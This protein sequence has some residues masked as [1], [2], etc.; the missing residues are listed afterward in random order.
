MTGF[1]PA[2]GLRSRKGI[3]PEHKLLVMHETIL[4][5]INQYL[6]RS[7]A[8]DRLYAKILQSV[9]HA[10]DNQPPD[11]WSDRY[12]VLKWIEVFRDYDLP[13][14]ETTS[15]IAASSL[16]DDARLIE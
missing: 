16:D 1:Y 5:E 12:S 3:M 10:I 8:S 11:F 2:I 13:E 9:C 7:D 4:T 14:L 6:R 15:G